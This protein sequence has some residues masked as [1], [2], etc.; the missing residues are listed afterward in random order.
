MHIIKRQVELAVLHLLCQ[1]YWWIT[2]KEH[3]SHNINHT[4]LIVCDLNQLQYRAKQF[5]SRHTNNHGHVY[6]HEVNNSV[7]AESRMLQLQN[8]VGVCIVEWWL[9]LLL[10]SISLRQWSIS[11]IRAGANGPAGQVLA[12][13]HF[14]RRTP[15]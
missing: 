3:R 1:L 13:P 6:V 14:T 4:Y 2:A 5:T 7:S 11:R 9:K 15:S 8:W 12:W 10:K